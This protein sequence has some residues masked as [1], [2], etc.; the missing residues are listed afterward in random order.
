MQQKDI[1][2]NRSQLRGTEMEKV[3]FCGA[4]AASLL[5]DQAIGVSE[6]LECMM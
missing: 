1:A 3:V 2:P 4:K 5:S 6:T